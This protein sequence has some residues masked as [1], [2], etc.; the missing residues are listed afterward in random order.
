MLKG[1]VWG[2]QEAEKKNKKGRA[3]G[4][5]VIG[6]RKELLEKATKMEKKRERIMLRRVRVERDRCRIVGV[7]MRNENW[8]EIMRKLER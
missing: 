7:Y 8:D 3:R 2:I 5:M 4:E 1:Y 6:I